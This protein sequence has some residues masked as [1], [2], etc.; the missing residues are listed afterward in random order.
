MAVQYSVISL[1]PIVYTSPI[2]KRGKTFRC[3]GLT[4]NYLFQMRQNRLQH[5]QTDFVGPRQGHRGDLPSQVAV[6]DVFSVHR[7][8]FFPK[9]L[10]DTVTGL[11]VGL[12]DLCRFSIYSWR[13][14]FID[15]VL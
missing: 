3:K 5:K 2:A 14:N 9:G 1:L 8:V 11:D 4:G 6:S 7:G 15:V 13:L 10:R 12:E